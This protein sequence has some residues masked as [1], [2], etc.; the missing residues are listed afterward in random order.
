MYI[1]LFQGESN[2][3]HTLYEINFK[4]IF[5]SLIKNLTFQLIFESK[6]FVLKSCSPPD[7]IHNRR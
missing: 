6:V 7:C 3:F 2:L 5:L 1:I 4:S